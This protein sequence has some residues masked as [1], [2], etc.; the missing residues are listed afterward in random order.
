MVVDLDTLGVADPIANFPVK[1]ELLFIPEDLVLFRR[2]EVLNATTV[3]FN[4]IWCRQMHDLAGVQMMLLIETGCILPDG[5]SQLVKRSLFSWYLYFTGCSNNKR[6]KAFANKPNTIITPIL[7]D[8][9]T[10]A[11]AIAAISD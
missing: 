11:A 7:A 1:I 3:G 9:A 4:L 6:F 8:L 5:K 2:G 10:S